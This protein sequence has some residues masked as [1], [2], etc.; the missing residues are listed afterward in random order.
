MTD[1]AGAARTTLNVC[2]AVARPLELT[3]RQGPMSVWLRLAGPSTVADHATVSGVDGV[4]R[5]SI[6]L[7][8]LEQGSLVDGRLMIPDAPTRCWSVKDV[9]RIELTEGRRP[10]SVRAASFDA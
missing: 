1:L 2:G 9:V 7:S 8:W 10:D 5:A 6:P 3:E 4:F